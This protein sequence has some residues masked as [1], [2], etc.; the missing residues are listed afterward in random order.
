MKGQNMNIM[1]AFPS[2]YLKASDIPDGQFVPVI[3]ER[4]EIENVAGNDDPNDEK[5]VLYFTGKTKGFVL[6]KTNA[7]AIAAGY[8]EQTP[9]WTG[10]QILLYRTETAFQGKQMP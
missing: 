3:M 1:S 7:N 4:V 9:G 2:K 8:G 5:P 10:Q 6:N